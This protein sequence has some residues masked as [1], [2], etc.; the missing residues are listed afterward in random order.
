MEHEH[1]ATGEVLIL[2]HRFEN[3]LIAFDEVYNREILPKLDNDY[4]LSEEDIIFLSRFILNSDALNDDMF[5]KVIEDN[6]KY[7]GLKELEDYD[8][9][10]DI[11]DDAW[12]IVFIQNSVQ[13][14][15]M[16]DPDRLKKILKQWPRYF[17]KIKLILAQI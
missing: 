14:D 7:I 17:E 4:E 16:K 10:F 8:G 1:E 3:S 15:K 5:K 9:S 11:V 6:P 13:K 2:K 12:I